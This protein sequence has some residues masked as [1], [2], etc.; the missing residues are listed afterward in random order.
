MATVT[1]SPLVAS[2][3]G[4]LGNSCLRR[5]YG[6][7]IW[8]NTPQPPYVATP[9]RQAWSNALAYAYSLLAVVRDELI[10]A[11]DHAPSSRRWGWWPWIVHT[12][13]SAPKSAGL[14][15]LFPFDSELSPP[16]LFTVQPIGAGWIRVTWDGPHND[17]AHYFCI[18]RR[19]IDVLHSTIWTFGNWW[20]DSKASVGS[21]DLDCDNPTNVYRIWGAYARVSDSVPSGFQHRNVTL[22]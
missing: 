13:V 3:A 12:G 21:V 8:E 5:Q 18:C 22:T 2:I 20:F 7:T 6:R 9:A 4:R 16:T 14:V 11:Q 10:A 15:Q 1:L 19:R 17:D